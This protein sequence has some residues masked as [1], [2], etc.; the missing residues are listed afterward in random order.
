M[1]RVVNDSELVTRVRHQNRVGNQ[2]RREKQLQEG[3]VQ[4]GGLWIPTATKQRA[5][6][7]AEQ[8]GLS[9]STVVTL[10]L[11]RLDDA[12]VDA[13][14]HLLAS[15]ANASRLLAAIAD[16]RAGRNLEVKKLLPDDD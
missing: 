11:D 1:A 15:P 4:L 3:K 5:Q 7:L 14:A 8:A 10:A 6:A 9:L 2:R 16:H 12:E 13:T